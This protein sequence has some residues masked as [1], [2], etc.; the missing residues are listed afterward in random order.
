MAIARKKEARKERKSW[1][2]KASLLFTFP[3]GSI[4]YP[5]M[6]GLGVLLCTPLTRLPIVRGGLSIFNNEEALYA[7]L[8][9]PR[10]IYSILFFF[11]SLPLRPLLQMSTPSFP[12]ESLRARKPTSAF[13]RG[14]D[15]YPSECMASPR[16]ACIHSPGLGYGQ[17]R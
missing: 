6:K 14:I 9:V 8:K 3:P 7:V 15:S 4:Y 2:I 16:F 13:H 10:P 5:L 11:F 17:L 1:S 12:F